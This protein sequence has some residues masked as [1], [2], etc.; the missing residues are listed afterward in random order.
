MPGTNHFGRMQY[1][2]ARGLREIVAPRQTMS[3]AQWQAVLE[4]FGGL[5]IFCGHAGTEENRGI[6]PDHLVPVTR[7]GELVIGNTVP[8]CQSCNDSR[9]EKEWRPFLRATFPGDAE[10]QILRVESHLSKFDYKPVSLEAALSA[11]ERKSYSALLKQWKVMLDKARRLK[12]SAEKRR[13]DAD[14]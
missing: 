11:S 6:V 2:V 4:E 12:N 14:Q 1:H 7:F 9:G 3:K 13:R 5:C 8:A 10:A